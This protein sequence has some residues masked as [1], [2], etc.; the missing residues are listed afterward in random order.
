MQ[1]VLISGGTGLVGGKLCALLDEKNISYHVLTRHPKA[2]HEYKWDISSSYMDER[3]FE[4]VDTLMHLAGAGV[5]DHR[6]T[7]AYK[8]EILQSRIQSTDLLFNWVQKTKFPIRQ[9]IGASAVGYYG[10]T[11]DMQVQE[12]SVSGQGFLAEVCQKWEDSHRQFEQVCTTAIVRIG[13]V[14]SEDGGALSRLLTPAKMGVAA[15]FGK[16]EQ[17]FPW[18]D[19]EDLTHILYQ[20]GLQGW[21]G[22]YNAVAPEELQFKDFAKRLAKRYRKIVMP[23]STPEIFPRIAMGAQA[24]MLLLGQRVSSQKLIHKGYSFIHPQFV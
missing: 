10:D 21:E 6:W 14:L 5:G 2:P 18:I 1:K 19:M 4:G 9:Y 13:V 11:G 24:D 23:I 15:Y 7:S 16:G 3:A 22:I 17:Y 20:I 12:D 8:H